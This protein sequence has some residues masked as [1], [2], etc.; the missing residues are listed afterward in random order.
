MWRLLIL[1][2]DSTVVLYSLHK[3]EVIQQLTD[4]RALAVE[5]ILPKAETFA[6]V[7][8]SGFLEIYKE[9]DKKQTPKSSINLNTGDIADVQLYLPC[10]DR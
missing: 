6:V 9:E 4:K 5:W 10:A 7:M 3:H 1:Y 2:E 8:A